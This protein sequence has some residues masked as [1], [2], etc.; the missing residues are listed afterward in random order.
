MLLTAASMLEAAHAAVPKISTADAQAKMAEGALLLDIRDAPELQ[1]NGRAA[2]SHHIPRGMLEFR[3]DPAT[4]FH[5]PEMRFDRPVIVHCASG[6]RA[7]LA[8]K[9]LKDMGYAEVFNLGGLQDWKDGGGPASEP[10]DPG[11]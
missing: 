4:Q 1:M 6:G 11:M 7:A 2:G 5:D 3:A 10:V 8:G 9:L